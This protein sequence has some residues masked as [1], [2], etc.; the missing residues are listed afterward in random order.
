MTRPE[1]MLIDYWLVTRA[2]GIAFR[3][4]QSEEYWRAVMELEKVYPL[5]W[6]NAMRTYFEGD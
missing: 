6:D 2:L 5:A 4:D 1:P 3:N